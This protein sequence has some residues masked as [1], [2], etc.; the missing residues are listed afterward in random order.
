MPANNLWKTPHIGPLQSKLLNLWPFA[1]CESLVT[2]ILV[3]GRAKKKQLTRT[4]GCPGL[5]PAVPHCLPVVA[6]SSTGSARHPEWWSAASSTAAV[7]SGASLPG[8]AHKQA[9]HMYFTRTKFWSNV[10]VNLCVGYKFV[11]HRSKPWL[12]RDSFPHLVTST[13]LLL[14]PT[15]YICQ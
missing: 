7:F 13:S 9:R 11:R 14:L 10:S 1:L 3:G 2:V 6:V 15:Q 4:E 12:W 5:P 8:P